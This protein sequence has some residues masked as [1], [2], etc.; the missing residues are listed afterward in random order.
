MFSASKNQQPASQIIETTAMLKLQQQ[1]ELE[2]SQDNKPMMNSNT[3]QM[4]SG[5]DESRKCQ[6]VFQS[7]QV[8]V[9]SEKN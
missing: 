9:P 3:P 8:R 2:N 4:V 1:K 7:Y 6:D 5:R